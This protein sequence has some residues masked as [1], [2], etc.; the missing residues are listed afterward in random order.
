MQHPI[1]LF[2]FLILPFDWFIDPPS[3]L[4]NLLFEDCCDSAPSYDSSFLSRPTYSD[5]RS[6]FN[7]FDPRGLNNNNMTMDSSKYDFQI[8]NF[9]PIPSPLSI[10]SSSSLSSIDSQDIPKTIIPPSLETSKP[11]CPSSIQFLDNTMDYG[12]E[13]YKDDHL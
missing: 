5:L 10:T 12:I 4:D 1:D 9:S 7:I 2:V 6:E 13:K 8:L 11:I 3:S